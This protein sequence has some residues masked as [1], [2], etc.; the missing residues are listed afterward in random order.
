M[1]AVRFQDTLHLETNYPNPQPGYGEALI[2]ISR[3]GICNT[4]LELIRGYKGFRGVLGHEFAGVVEGGERDGQR[5]VG[6]I[7]IACGTCSLCNDGIPSQCENRATLGINHKDGI[8]A[9]YATLPVENLHL[10]PDVITDEQAVFIEPLA[11]SLQMLHLTHISPHDRVIVIGA[12]KLGLLTA[13]V[14]ALTGCDLTVIGRHSQQH[15]LL[16]G[17][18][19]PSKFP[20]DLEARSA[21]LVIDCTG[22][23]EGF[24]D[25][26]ELVRSRGTIHL[27]STYYG[28]LGVD[29]TRIVVDEIKVETSRCGPFDAAIRLLARGLI[30]V[31]SLVDA[32]YPLEKALQAFEHAGR[33]GS[34]KVILDIA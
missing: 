33:K 23:A 11:A 13:Q 4:D 8:F 31:D 20:G 25:A 27:K 19:I 10:I 7:N 1:K 22:T 28:L 21:D 2:R 26:L 17:W 29:L 3:A 12:G 16:A 24:A 6:E 18:S 34:L 30:D 5:V 15:S 9:E 14:A 32:H